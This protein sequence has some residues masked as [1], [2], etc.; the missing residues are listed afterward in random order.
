MLHSICR[1]QSVVLSSLDHL[2]RT[3]QELLLPVRCCV[4]ASKRTRYL[5]G[6]WTLESSAG[7]RQSQNYYIQYSIN[8]RRHAT[9]YH[10]PA[11]LANLSPPTE[12]LAI[13]LHLC[14]AASHPNS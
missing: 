1:S 12:A 5:S 7:D 10:L 6:L 11:S 14:A 3:A 2:P 13:T 4:P 9:T 8:N